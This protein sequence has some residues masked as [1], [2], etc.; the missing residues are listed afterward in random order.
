MT[1]ILEA[2]ERFRAARKTSV[3]WG[4]GTP[5]SPE[6]ELRS[7]IGAVEALEAGNVRD[8]RPSRSVL[9]EAKAAYG[10][11]DARLDHLTTRQIRALCWDPDS[12]ME[13]AFVRGIAAHPALFQ[14]R[15]WI[16]GLLDS[17]LVRWRSMPQPDACE[18]LLRR[19]VEAFRGRSPRIDMYRSVASRLFSG[20]A[21]QWLGELI[22]SERRTVPETLREWR[23]EPSTGLGEAA[24]NAAVVEWTR[25][26]NEKKGTLV[27]ATAYGWFRQLTQELLV[28]DLIGPEAIADAVSCLVLWDQ[29]VQDERIHEDLRTFLITDRRFGDPRV[30]NRKT[31][32]DLC[33]R[34]ARQRAI[35]W[36]AK[37][38]LLFFFKFVIQHDPH[39]RKDFWLRYISSA[40]DGHVALCEQDAAR[41]RA[42]VKERLSYSSVIG[43][44]GTSAFL[45][46]FRGAREDLL[47]IEFSKTGNALYIHN[48]DRFIAR[49]KSIRGRDFDLRADLKNSSTSVY[50]AVHANAWTH[51]VQAFL[52]SNGVRPG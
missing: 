32:W 1:G 9:Q 27:G 45:M 34:D 15:R 50:Q 16:E 38:D 20:S 48:A 51:G 35:G 46:R 26:F 3:G 31:I 28:S 40:I 29:A 43:G 11:A 41:L 22:V 8:P 5:V 47:C 4:L 12:A 44:Q 6:V 19:A 7:V 25:R 14:N 10:S 49:C 18:H 37:G 52:A 13:P 39:G 24:A 17:Y 30:P 33:A 42:E 23:V 2:F 36:L 21:P